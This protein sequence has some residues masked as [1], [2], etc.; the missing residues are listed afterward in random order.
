M[1]SDSATCVLKNGEPFPSTANSSVLNPAS[2][3]RARTV[4]HL[5][6]ASYAF[7]TDKEALLIDMLHVS[8]GPNEEESSRIPSSRQVEEGKAG[9]IVPHEVRLNP[10]KNHQLC[11]QLV[12]NELFMDGDIVDLQ[13]RVSRE[14]PWWWRKTFKEFSV[15]N[16]SANSDTDRESFR[17]LFATSEDDSETCSLVLAKAHSSEG[18]RWQSET[19]GGDDLRCDREMLDRMKRVLGAEGYHISLRNSEHF[20]RYILHKS[21]HSYQ[22]CETGGSSYGRQLWKK[23]S[24]EEREWLSVQPFDLQSGSSGNV[25]MEHSSFGASFPLERLQPSV[26]TYDASIQETDYNVVVIGKARSG[27]S[28]LINWLFNESLCEVGDEK[29]AVSTS[30]TGASFHAYN[31][32]FTDA[33]D[34]VRKV[35]VIDTVGLC[36]GNIPRE[37]LD[38]FLQMVLQNR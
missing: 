9:A 15:A 31:G 16:T 12:D 2:L 36:D 32:R 23:L 34:N 19:E 28:C 20:C 25:A 13:W 5:K 17:I 7:G 24:T 21:W 38:Q 11:C 35:K 4:V 33:S 8:G 18:G 1:V 10:S 27:K 6:N 26:F 29:K 22:I 3:A 14:G 37:R 30:T